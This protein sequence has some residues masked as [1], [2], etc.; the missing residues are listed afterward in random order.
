M[1]LHKIYYLSL[2]LTNASFADA[3][4]DFILPSDKVIH[5]VKFLLRGTELPIERI[6]GEVIRTRL[7]QDSNIIQKGSN[8]LM[9]IVS[10]SQT[11]TYKRSFTVFKSKTREGIAEIGIVL[12]E[13]VYFCYSPKKMIFDEICM[14]LFYGHS[15]YYL[16]A[17]PTAERIELKEGDYPTHHGVMLK[18]NPRYISR[19]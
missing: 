16:D 4:L 12:E 7:H 6:N 17:V 19:E 15:R 18:N 2:L 9:L 5:D 10:L 13:A 3:T 1:S 14:N 8:T 11:E